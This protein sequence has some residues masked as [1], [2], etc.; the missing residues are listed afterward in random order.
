MPAIRL[1]RR[2]LGAS[3]S[4]RRGFRSRGVALLG[5][6]AI[7][8]AVLAPACADSPIIKTQSLVLADTPA[9]G[10]T[11]VQ[12]TQAFRTMKIIL[13]FNGD[14]IEL[15]TI[16]VTPSTPVTVNGKRG[17]FGDLTPTQQQQ[18][19]QALQA[20]PPIDVT[21]ITTE[22]VNAA[23]AG[24]M[25]PGVSVTKAMRI[26]L[27]INGDR[28]ELDGTNLTPDIPV[29]VNGKSGRFGD[30][31][32]TQQQQLRQALGKLKTLPAELPASIDVIVKDALRNANLSENV[33]G[34]V[35]EQLNK[36]TP[37]TAS[38]D[39]AN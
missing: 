16:D 7:S 39:A 24:G 14:K 11:T 25:K 18:L 8:L 10:S 9:S 3:V 35:M 32:P 2:A 38:G 29:T 6:S 1:I 5:V 17:L 36:Q 28:V 12:T 33:M 21:T 26:I 27:N 31:T 34:Q 37:D 22:A 20:V 23:K 13:D 19:R 30:L 15:D 4:N